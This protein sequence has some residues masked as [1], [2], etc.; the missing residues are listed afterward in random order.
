[1]ASGTSIPTAQAQPDSA[2]QAW[3]RWLA[4]GVV[5]V[6]VAVVAVFWTGDGGRLLLA[7]GGVLAAARGGALLRGEGATRPV[8]AA[9]ELVGVG[10]LVVAA[11]SAPL[12]GWV[13]LVGAP[14][15]FLSA[16][17]G[18]VARGGAA[19][20]GGQALLVWSGLLAALLVAAGVGAGEE[21]AAGVAT[22]VGALGLAG[23]GIAVLVGAANL[24]AV[25]ARPAPAP[26]PAG[27][28]GCACGAGGCGGM[29][30]A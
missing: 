17:L 7:A 22:V 28:A 21:R 15:L 18:L 20:R 11:V 13:L 10:A 12:T 30:S 9:A 26:V 4:L 29:E 5:L 8:G 24:R 6:A 27:C 2:P 23:L 19:R 14:L 25:A 16:G 3:P 1:M